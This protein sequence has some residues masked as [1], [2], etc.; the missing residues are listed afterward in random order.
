MS[1]ILGTLVPVVGSQDLGQPQPHGFSGYSPCD[2]CNELESN[3]CSFSRVRLQTANGSL[4][5][6]SGGW[7][8]YSHDSTRHCYHR[9]TLQCLHPCIRLLPGY[10]IYSW[11]P[12]G[13][14][15]A[16]M[17]FVSLAPAVLISCKCCKGLW[18]R[19]FRTVTWAVLLA[20]W[21]LAGGG[22]AEMQEAASQ[23]G[24][25]QWY[26]GLFPWNHSVLLCLW[27]YDKSCCLKDLR[28]VFTAIFP[29]F[30]LHLAPF[31]H[32]N[33]FCKWL[34]H[35]TLRFIS[36]ENAVSF[37]NTSRLWIFQILTLCFLLN[38]KFHL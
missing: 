26:C 7:H 33:L 29:L 8:L 2:C 4:I 13:S 37:S 28:N 1:H 16:S 36:P 31:S 25:G 17:A 14:C 35:N 34:L 10:S 6:G 15:Q 11:N 32:V 24:S 22:A 23:G 21:A 27:A 5:L 12:G 30:Y 19:P 20:N 9:G 18:R 38:Y 3:A